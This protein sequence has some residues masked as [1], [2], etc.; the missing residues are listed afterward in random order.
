M[1]VAAAGVCLYKKVAYQAGNDE[2]KALANSLY[3]KLQ[4]WNV[5]LRFVMCFVESKQK[6]VRQMT[7]ECFGDKNALFDLQH[8]RILNLAS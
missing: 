1:V 8:N 7:W 6:S 5:Q 4:T 3:R 2:V